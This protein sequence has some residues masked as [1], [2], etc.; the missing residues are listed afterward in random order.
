MEE[1]R[2]T[3]TTNISHFVW[4]QL[5]AMEHPYPVFHL[6]LRS[7]LGREDKLWRL[8]W[9][10]GIKYYYEFRPGSTCESNRRL[11]SQLQRSVDLDFLT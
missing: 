10:S 1:K 3:T 4:F 11:R 7:M 5:V 6:E 9:P 2:A 8:S